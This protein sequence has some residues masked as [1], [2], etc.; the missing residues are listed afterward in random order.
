M[1][2]CLKSIEKYTNLKYH[3]LILV[4]DGSAATT[5]HLVVDYANKLGAMM[6]RNETALGYTKAAN[7]GLQKVQTAYCLLLNSDTIV[8][9]GWLEYLI[10]CAS[11]Y[12]QTACVQP[13]L[14]QQAGNLFPNFSLLTASGKSMIP[15]G[16]VLNEYSRRISLNSARLY[17][18]VSFLN[19]FCYLINRQALNQVGYLDEETF[20]RGY[21]E[22][23][24]FS[25]R[26]Q[27]A[28]WDLRV[29]DDC[30]IYHA[31]SKSFTPQIRD[32]IT[33]TAKS[34]LQ[35]KHGKP[36]VSALL[37]EMAE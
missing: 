29:A 26:V 3:K 34:A 7:K 27:D 18:R 17:P 28:G 22:E 16:L 21:G 10:H 33:T 5:Q 4:D 37:Q 14:M 31:K 8:T 19:G 2:S 32:E 6:I 15:Q 25:I 11:S 36:K 9:P 24:D 12:P 35:A 23:D 13:F 30:Y 1:Q 20:P